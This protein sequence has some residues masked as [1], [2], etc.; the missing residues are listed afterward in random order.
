MKIPRTQLIQPLE[1]TE[2][3][4]EKELLGKE[5]SDNKAKLLK[6]ADE[7][8]EWEKEKALLI[9]KIDV[10]NERKLDLEKEKED[11]SKEDEVQ[12]IQP[13]VERST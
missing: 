10:L 6:L 3:E 7:K 5:L 1:L 11:K 2:L 12:I 4:K 13:F 9:E 8:K